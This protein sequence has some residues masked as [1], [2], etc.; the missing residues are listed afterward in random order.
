MQSIFSGYDGIKFKIKG[1]G[2]EIIVS[3][4]C[5]IENVTAFS[6]HIWG[7]KSEQ[8]QIQQESTLSPQQSP[9]L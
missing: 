1:M 4:K 3:I 5:V 2:R 7:Q 8:I 6:D 9:R